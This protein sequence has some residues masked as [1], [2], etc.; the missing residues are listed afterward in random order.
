[1]PFRKFYITFSY[2]VEKREKTELFFIPYPIFMAF[3]KTSFESRMIFELLFKIA[4]L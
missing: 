3:R 4:W 1:L 2:T